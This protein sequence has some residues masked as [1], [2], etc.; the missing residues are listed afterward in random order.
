MRVEIRKIDSARRREVNISEWNADVKAFVRD[1]NGID[2]M[3]FGD[4]LDQFQNRQL[5]ASERYEAALCACVMALVGEDGEPI[6][7]LDQL[8]T[9]KEASSAPT[10]RILNMLL[11]TDAE[12]SSLKKD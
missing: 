8:E 9:L 12:D 5:P 6:L 10:Y 11:D 2:R 3:V 4:Q 1:L 7:S